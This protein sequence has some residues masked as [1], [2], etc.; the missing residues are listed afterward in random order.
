MLSDFYQ[1]HSSIFLAAGLYLPLTLFWNYAKSN[2]KKTWEYK[3]APHLQ[4][5]PLD[6]GPADHIKAFISWIFLFL[7]VFSVSPG[8]YYLGKRDE[9]TPLLV[10]CNNFLT[11]FLLARRI[12]KRSVRLLIVDTNGINVWC[13][14]GEGKFSAE[15]I[16]DKA[17]LF[18]LRRE[19]R[20]T[21]MILPKLC[22]SGVRMS[23]LRKAGFKP[24]IGPMYAKDLPQYL[25][26]GEFRDRKNDHCRFGL[27]ARMFTAVPTSV[28]FLYWFLGIYI[29]TFWAVNVSI[30]WVAA[31]LAFLYPVLFPYLPGKQFAVKGIAL[32]VLNALF[33]YGCIWLEGIHT[34]AALF[35]ILFGLATSMFISLSYTGNSPV[36]NYDSVRKETARFLPVVVMLYVLLIPVKIFLG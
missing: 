6:L 10:T 4:A 12:G 19:K 14:A 32:G 29:L 34:G 23:D 35:W 31:V 5:L 21:E 27:Q 30:I 28:Q 20:N 1:D 25:D 9:N 2:R 7:G 33:I 8:Y 11:V 13:S 18:G 16:I 36:S 22:L 24:V 17:E 3:P 26:R 15:E